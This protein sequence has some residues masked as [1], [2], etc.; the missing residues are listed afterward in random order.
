[1]GGFRIYFHDSGKVRAERVGVSIVTDDCVFD[2]PYEREYDFYI[3]LLKN[4][5]NLYLGKKSTISGIEQGSVRMKLEN[6]GT[7]KAVKLMYLLTEEELEL[8]KSLH[9]FTCI[10]Y[11]P[12]HDFICEIL[13][14][15]EYSIT[16]YYINDFNEKLNKINNIEKL[17]HEVIETSNE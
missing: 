3:K 5:E 4:I 7:E 13:C 17:R 12:E 8:E 16:R 10:D 14:S 6:N 11:V 15:I 1:M 9:S 2:F